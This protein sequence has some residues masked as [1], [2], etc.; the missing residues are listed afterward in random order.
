MSERNRLP[1][2]PS[3]EALAVVHLYRA[4]CYIADAMMEDGTSDCLEYRELDGAL[5]AARMIASSIDSSIR[6]HPAVKKAEEAFLLKWIALDGTDEP[7]FLAFSV[8]P[9]DN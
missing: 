8:T 7:A 3:P 2:P 9:S 6:R 4:C 1:D 5:F